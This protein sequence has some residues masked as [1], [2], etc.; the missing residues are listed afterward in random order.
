MVHQHFKLAPSFTVAENIILGAEPMKS[1][2]RIDRVRAESQ[3]AELGHRFGLDLDPARHRR[4]AA[5]RPPAAGRDP[6]GA[7]SRRRRS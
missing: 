1:F 4:R 6:E 3:T 5:G 7:L 2:G